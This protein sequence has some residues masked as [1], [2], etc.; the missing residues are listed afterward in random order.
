MEI[1]REGYRPATS[2]F[3]PLYP[4]LL[5]LAGPKDS[6]MAIWG[7]CLSSIAL[8]LG[9]MVL[10]RLTRIDCDEH[11]S[12]LVVWL[13]AFCPTTAVFSAV[14]TDALFLFL[15]TASFLAARRQLWLWCGV[16]ALLASLTR[17]SGVLIWVALLCEYWL[18]KRQGGKTKWPHVFYL[19]GPLVGFV[20]FQLYIGWRFGDLT[21]GV[22][23]HQA[24]GRHWNAPWEPLWRDAVNIF[25]GRNLDAITL[26]NWAAT[27]LGIYL[28]VQRRYPQPL[29]Y[30]LFLGG[31]LLMQLSFG[32]TT[33]PFTN[34]SLRFLSTT[35]PFAQALARLAEPTLKSRISR[36]CLIAI[37]LLV[38]AI[39]SYLFGKKWFVTG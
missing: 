5:R 2:P 34:S 15:V 18:W 35:F 16:W 20:A 1:A 12:N 11:T 21:G 25:N 14:Y 26:F 32:R 13:V 23:S 30:R 28:V 24:Y 36:W 39:F 29:S 6:Q 19:C 33:A 7:V 4:W 22:Q 37:Y 27:L 9:L 31:I 8:L 38:C 3:F 10:Y 17:N